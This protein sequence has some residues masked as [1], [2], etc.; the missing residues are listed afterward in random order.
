MFHGLEGVVLVFRQRLQR[1]LVD[2]LIEVEHFEAL[3]AEHFAVRVDLGGFAARRGDV[4]DFLLAFAGAGNV[5]VQRGQAVGVFHRGGVEAQQRGDAVTVDEIA[6]AEFEDL[7]VQLPEAVVLFRVVLRHLFEVGQDLLADGLRDLAQDD[8]FLKRFAGNVQG[9]VLGVHHALEEGEVVGDELLVFTLDEHAAGVEI[10]P[11]VLAVRAEVVL[12]DVGN[13]Q[14]GVELHRS[15]HGQVQ[16]VERIFL[17]V[18]QELVKF[19]VLFLLD[20]EL[21]LAPQ[22]GRRVHAFAVHEDGEGDEARMRADD[23]FDAVFFQKLLVAFLDEG[24]DGGAALDVGLIRGFLHGKRAG[25]VGNP[26][27]GG[28]VAGGGE[29]GHFNLVRDHEHGIEADAEASDDVGSVAGRAVFGGLGVFLEEGF[30]TGVGDGPEVFDHLV[31]GHADA[32]IGDGQAILHFVR[33]NPDFE[34]QLGITDGLVL[35]L[36]L[37]ETQLVQRIRGVGNELTQKNLPVG[38]Q[39]VGEDIQNLTGFG[40]EFMIGGLFRHGNPP[41]KSW[42]GCAR[43]SSPKNKFAC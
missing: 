9:Q 17:V 31:A 37:E 32:C 41:A 22:G 19:V 27:V 24:P 2:G 4:P 10:Q 12:G 1:E 42:P 8:V 36:A 20:G 35:R 18:G 29:R 3:A 14:Q 26:A 39:G 13:E 43:R 34:R 25:P 40:T 15:V 30:R 5:V 33:R 23:P 11:P 16:H 21:G 7:A 6:V 28:A 38:I